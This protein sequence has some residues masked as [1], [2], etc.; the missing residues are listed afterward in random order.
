[1][2]FDIFENECHATHVAGHQNHFLYFV[3]L[4][5]NVVRRERSI[6]HQNISIICI[7][8]KGESCDASGR[9]DTKTI[10]LI[11]I[12]L[13]RSIVRRERSIRHQNNFYNFCILKRSVVRH[14]Q[15][16]RH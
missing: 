9:L 15:L 2:S 13:K 11:F 7:F 16:I 5:G 3:F 8:W 14:E 1:L 12:F 6:R 4:K 10:F